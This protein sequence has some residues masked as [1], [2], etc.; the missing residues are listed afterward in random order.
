MAYTAD[1]SA[2]TLKANARYEREEAAIARVK[3]W[4]ELPFQ[5]HTRLTDKA[6][7]FPRYDWVPRTA[8][9]W[10]RNG[11]LL[12]RSAGG[13]GDSFMIPMGC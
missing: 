3:K 7:H 2:S 4:I 5:W 11:E 1:S 13:E 10:K 12:P 6:V 9:A 8:I